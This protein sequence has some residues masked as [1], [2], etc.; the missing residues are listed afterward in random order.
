MAIEPREANYASST[1]VLLDPS[2]GVI[3]QANLDAGGQWD[4]SRGG[5]YQSF[6]S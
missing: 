4:L 2:S 6:G 3:H 1:Q 5:V